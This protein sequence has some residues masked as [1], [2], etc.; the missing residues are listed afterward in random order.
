MKKRMKAARCPKSGFTTLNRHHLA[1][2]RKSNSVDPALLLWKGTPL[3]RAYFNLPVLTPFTLFLYDWTE[4]Q[5]HK[6]A[7]IASVTVTI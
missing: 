6:D 7:R 4:R 1:C 2:Q 3:D 5:L